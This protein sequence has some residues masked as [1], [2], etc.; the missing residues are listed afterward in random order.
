M[1]DLARIALAG[2]PIALADVLVQPL[3][4]HSLVR[5]AD[6]SWVVDGSVAIDEFQDRVGLHGLRG[7][8]TFDT[9][10]GYALHR[11]GRLPVVGD[12][13]TDRTGRYEIVDMDGRRIDKLVFT[14]HQEEDG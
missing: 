3:V 10:A 6:G 12:T 4:E 13:F 14:P 11:L 8:R 9:V 2:Q 7:S 5:R 1:K